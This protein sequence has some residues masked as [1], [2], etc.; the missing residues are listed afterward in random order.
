MTQT[1]P[2][3]EFAAVRKA[4]PGSRGDALAGLDL[5][6]ARGEFIAVLGPSGAG[7]STLFKL[8]AA[9]ER[10]SA[11][12]VSVGGQD[13][14]RLSR[15][16]VPWFRRKLGLT[17]QDT[18]LLDDRS[19]LDNV[20]LPLLCTGSFGEQAVARGRAALDKVGLR[21]FEKALPATLSGGEQQRVALARAI[22]NRPAV[23]LADEPTANLD[24]A[25]AERIVQIFADFHRLGTTVLVA[26]HTPDVLAGAATRTI[27]LA[28]GRLV[29]DERFAPPV[30]VPQGAQR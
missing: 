2:L 7:K 16:A 28:D 12:R 18:K 22:V 6:I 13:V 3:I 1:A 30:A 24:A 14:G 29:G 11:G 19:V 8:I 20:M 4:Y 27:R 17:F 23:L 26:T 25:A 10:P 9:I 21:Q 5:A 15:A